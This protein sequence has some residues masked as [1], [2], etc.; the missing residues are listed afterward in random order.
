[1]GGG[2]RSSMA[3]LRRSP[4]SIGAEEEG[5]CREEAEGRDEEVGTVT[6]VRLAELEL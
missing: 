6:D 2:G 1:M 4:I 3:S 5:G